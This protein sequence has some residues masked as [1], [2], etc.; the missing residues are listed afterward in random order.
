M[1]ELAIWD[2]SLE[3]GQA[4]EES[5]EQACRHTEMTEEVSTS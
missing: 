2:T 4:G 5:H 3:K 1:E